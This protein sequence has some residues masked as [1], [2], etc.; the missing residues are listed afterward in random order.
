MQHTER[1]VNNARDWHAG[2][3]RIIARIYRIR[4]FI[5][6]TYRA[7]CNFIKLSMRAR[8]KLFTI[9]HINRNVLSRLRTIFAQ[10]FNHNI[11]CI[12]SR[13]T[14]TRLET[15][16]SCIH[17]RTRALI[18]LLTTART[19]KKNNNSPTC[20]VS[21]VFGDLFLALSLC[22]AGL[23]CF[24]I[25]VVLLPVMCSAVDLFLYVYQDEPLSALCANV[26]SCSRLGLRLLLLLSLRGSADREPQAR[27]ERAASLSRI[28]Q[29][30]SRI[31]RDALDVT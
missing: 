28:N 23:R 11:L 18:A 31:S 14:L 17:I 12:S 7:K 16:V 24:W 2:S 27:S 10:D 5:I 25:L 1:I 30:I 26:R 6:S 19:D 4:F 8:H 9:S 22:S 20:R 15:R 3:M 13:S 21:S 29:H